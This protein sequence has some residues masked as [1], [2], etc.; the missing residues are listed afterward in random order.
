MDRESSSLL[1]TLRLVVSDMIAKC[2]E[3]GCFKPSYKEGNKK[4][5]KICRKLFRMNQHLCTGNSKNT[6]TNIS[7]IENN[8]DLEAGSDSDSD[9]I[10]PSKIEKLRKTPSR[11][12]K[13]PRTPSPLKIHPENSRE[14]FN[15]GVESKTVSETVEDEF[16]AHKKFKI[17][18]NYAKECKSPNKKQKSDTDTKNSSMQE[19][20][21]DP[22]NIIQTGP[23]LTSGDD[24]SVILRKFLEE[25]WNC[26]HP[27]KVDGDLLE[28]IIGV[29]S[30]SKTQI[31]N[32]FCYKRR[33]YKE[34]RKGLEE[35]LRKMSENR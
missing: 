12:V 20:I 32:F 22:V 13:I 18:N 8:I 25:I 26:Y 31:S 29:T 17:K 5:K 23:K 6:V 1:Y 21:N 27:E 10:M 33:R 28:Y 16:C 35:E 3:K 2:E 30:L 34:E 24:R 15:E 9:K 14:I 7:Q 4:L 11:P 19:G